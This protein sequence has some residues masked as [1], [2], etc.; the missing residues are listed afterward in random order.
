MSKFKNI[1]KK[2]TLVSIASAAMF[3][4]SNALAY[5]DLSQELNRINIE[6]TNLQEYI[7]YCYSHGMDCYASNDPAAEERANEEELER[8]KALWW[9]VYHSQFDLN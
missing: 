4:S 8:L 6:M 3:F 2:V 1:L 5:R 9:E 7:V